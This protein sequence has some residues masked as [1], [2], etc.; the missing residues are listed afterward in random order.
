MAPNNLSKSFSIEKK[1]SKATSSLFFP[2]FCFFITILI[3]QINLMSIG[4]FYTI[5]KAHRAP[6]NMNVFCLFKL[7]SRRQIS[8]ISLPQHKSEQLS[9]CVVTA[10]VPS[11]PLHRGA[12]SHR[13]AASDGSNLPRGFRGQTADGTCGAA[14]RAA[15]FAHAAEGQDHS[16]GTAS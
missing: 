16:Q 6:L 8:V 12:L 9:L 13:A 5:A 1:G 2:L 11:D 14:G 7:F 10:Q 15:S 3:Q 4:L